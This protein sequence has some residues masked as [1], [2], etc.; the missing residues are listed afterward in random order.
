M[1]QLAI[2][3]EGDMAA[4]D[5]G[6]L[7]ELPIDA[8]ILIEHS[9]AQELRVTWFALPLSELHVRVQVNPPRDHPRCEAE[10]ERR[11][12][13]AIVISAKSPMLQISDSEAENLSSEPKCPPAS[14]RIGVPF[15]IL[16]RHQVR[17]TV[18]K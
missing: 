10:V 14:V 5:G 4:D 17:P 18:N 16:S 13:S 3:A 6:R 15:H 11:G 9:S 2:L 12:V 7:F 1:V 8:P